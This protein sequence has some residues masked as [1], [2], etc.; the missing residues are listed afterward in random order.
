MHKHDRLAF[1][2][3]HLEKEPEKVS[4]AVHPMKEL[5]K[6][7]TYENYWMYLGSDL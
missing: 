6:G 3:W 1:P 2:D 5:L 7:N 4:E